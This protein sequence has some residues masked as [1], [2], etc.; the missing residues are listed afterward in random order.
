MAGVRS[1]VVRHALSMG[2]AAIASAAKCAVGQVASPAVPAAKTAPA[3]AASTAEQCEQFGR[4]MEAAVKQSDRRA[5]GE[6]IDWNLVLDRSLRDLQ[7]PA[8]ADRGFRS[9]VLDSINDSGGW[10]DQIVQQCANGASYRFL[11]AREIDGQKTVL[12]RLNGPSGI[13]Y[14]EYLLANAGGRLRASDA[15]IYLAG[16]RMSEMFRRSAI[17]LAQQLPKTWLERLTKPQSDYIAN[18][19]N[20]GKMAEKLREKKP[21]E[22]L[23]IYRELPAELQRDK[24]VLMIRYQAAMGAGDQELIAAVEDF[25][26]HYPNDVCLDFLLIDYYI[27]RREFAQALESIERVDRSVGGDPFLDSLR[28]DV[29]FRQ[30]DSAKA[31]QLAENAVNRVQDVADAVYTLIGLSLEAKDHARTLAGLRLLETR[32]QVQFADLKTVPEYAEFVKSRQGAEWIG[33]HPR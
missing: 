29:V 18:F 33:A 24:N 10:A 8:E 7:L 13:N 19:G 5:F 16:E 32:F 28:A 30:G 4:S 14:H 25:R 20:V 27:V 31:L 22:A 23:A 3:Q 12:F 9:G 26:H 6:M 21:A 1:F 11:R 2:V 17:P 15:V